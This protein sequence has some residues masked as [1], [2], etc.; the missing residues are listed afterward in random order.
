V[1]KVTRYNPETGRKVKVPADSAEAA[2]WSSRKPPKGFAGTLYQGFQI[3]G[4]AGAA[5]VA[6]KVGEK[7]TRKVSTSVA[8]AGRK[9]AQRGAKY[10][11]P[12]V[13][14][15]GEAAGLGA[16]ATVGTILSAALV[17]YGLGTEAFYPQRSKADRLDAALKALLDSRRAAEKR[18]GRKL[19]ADE[20][21]V[22]YNAYKETVVRIKANDPELGLRPGAG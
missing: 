13:V 12:A 17:A 4:G 16:A 9:L 20:N 18:L 19:T 1:R 22:F 2:T 11:I 7:V 3:G 5:H 10:G 8:S 15:A 6:G 21:R 14:A